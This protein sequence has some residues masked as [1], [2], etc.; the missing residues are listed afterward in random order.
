M[1]RVVVFLI[2]LGAVAWVIVYWIK[3][4]LARKALDGPEIVM[5]EII[6]KNARE[7]YRDLIEAVRCLEGILEDDSRFPALSI[8]RKEQAETVV[9][10]FEARQLGR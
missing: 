9:R 8:R 3:G 6:R 4:A 1:L 7:N 2:A 5:D 10:S